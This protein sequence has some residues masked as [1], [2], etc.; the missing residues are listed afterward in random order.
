MAYTNLELGPVQIL[1]GQLG[2]ET[3]IGP[4]EGGATLTDELTTVILRTDE[5]GETPQG[6]VTM[7]STGARVTANLADIVLSKLAKVIPGAVLITD[8]IDPTKQRLE[9]RSSVGTDLA[10]PATGYPSQRL[11]M[12]KI[13]AGVPSTSPADWIIAN[14]CAIVTNMNMAFNRGDQRVVPC[15]IWMLPHGANKVVYFFGDESATP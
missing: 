3:E 4:T 5:T 1:F 7:G 2:A 15:E 10:P 9:V 11:V 8:S 13:K 12:K 14:R 6:I